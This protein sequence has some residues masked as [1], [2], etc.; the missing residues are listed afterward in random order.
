MDISTKTKIIFS[1]DSMGRRALLL[2]HLIKLKIQPKICDDWQSALKDKSLITLISS[3]LIGG[4]RWEDKCLLITEG[5]LFKNHTASI[6]RK[7]QQTAAQD[8]STSIFQDLS[9]LKVGTAVVHIEHGVGRYQGLTTLDMSGQTNEYLTLTYGNDEKL[10]VPIHD[11][12]LVS[13]YSGTDLENAPLNRLGS[14]KWD[15]I[16]ERAA[17]KIQDVAAE[18]LE[19]YAQRVIKSGFS[20][21]FDKNEYLGFCQSFPFEETEDQQTA[22]RDV[23]DDMISSKPMDR[24]VCGDVGFGKTE[25][26]MRATYLAAHNNKQVAILVPTT[27]LAQQHYENFRDRFADLPV[28]VEV[29]SR[30]KTGKQQKEAI[31]S[32]SNGKIDIVIGTH[33]LL[34]KDIKFH[35]LGLLVI[36]E[37]HRFGVK[38]KE[39]MKAFRADID[40]LTM[41]ATPIPR[42]LN[43]ALSEIRDLS[44]IATPPA[45]RLAVK[46]FVKEIKNDVI[47]EAILRETMRGGQVYFLHNKVETIFAKQESLQSLFPDLK[48][49]IAHGQMREKE[50]ERIMFDFQKNKYHVLI[51]TTIIE[52]GI[53]I[54][55]ANTII[56]ERADNFGLAQLHQL[57]GRVGRSHHQAY[58]YLLTPPFDSLSK[59]AMKRLDALKETDSLGAGFM[60]ANHDLEIRGAGELLG[61]EQSGNIEGIGFSLYMELLQ[62]T[63]S[64]LQSGKDISKISFNDVINSTEVELRI[65]ALI[66]E[67][68]LFDVHTRLTFYKRISNV[69]N[70]QALDEIKIELVDRFGL[71]PIQVEN[72]FDTAHLRIDAKGLDIKKVEMHSGGGSIQFIETPNIDPITIIKMV[73]LQPDCYQLSKSERILI[74][75]GF[76]KAEERIEFMKE[77]FKKLAL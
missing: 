48:I 63:V 5:D 52:T 72:L 69:E 45:K 51:C 66:P 12:H 61:K 13:R 74:K 44:I 20:N 3:P 57:R 22:I 73:Q 67:T 15:K 39:Q 16:K 25:V 31:E 9:E 6:S 4:F 64:A 46:T 75:K 76:L 8:F 53:D 23:L 58:A 21:A 7:K 65:P 35:N 56:M 77:T 30:F 62:K 37:E 17:K 2:E 50:L 54:P 28:N 10:Y 59:N 60:L 55:N 18:L 34:S 68:Y 36:D 11:L 32:L 38:H 19:I 1:A 26:A 70:H 27:L 24:L 42:T 29:L 49:A 47:K 14:D 40:I 43:M 33:K 41:T 71:L